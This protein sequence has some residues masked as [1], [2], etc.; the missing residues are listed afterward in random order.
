LIVT[1]VQEQ[2]NLVEYLALVN[3]YIDNN[4]T[5][6]MP[7]IPPSLDAVNTMCTFAG[8]SP[9]H[10]MG[11]YMFREAP[12][13]VRDIAVNALMAGCLPEYMP[14]ILAAHEVMFAR[15]PRD[16]DLFGTAHMTQT[17][18]TSVPA[19]VINGPIRHRLGIRSGP[20]SFGPGSRA[21]AAIGRAI[22]L[23]LL[24]LASG[25]PTAAGRSAVGSTFRLTAVFGEDEEHSPWTPL[26]VIAGYQPTDSTVTMMKITQPDQFVFR[27][28]SAERLLDVILDH[29]TTLSHFTDGL[30]IPEDPDLARRE[31]S[32]WRDAPR[33]SP[34]SGLGGGEGQSGASG[35]G[36]GGG[37]QLVLLGEE[38]RA[39]LAAWSHEQIREYLFG[40]RGAGRRG[41]T[42]GEMRFVGFI[43]LS[44]GF[45]DDDPDSKFI[46][47]RGRGTNLFPVAV[48]GHGWSS[49]LISGGS[50]MKKLPEIPAVRPIRVSGGKSSPI[51]EYVR[52]VEEAMESELGDSLPIL[53]PDPPAIE[54]MLAAS[55]RSSEEVLGRFERTVAGE[56]IYSWPFT[57]GEVA[58]TAH[59]AGL[60]HRTTNSSR[61]LWNVHGCS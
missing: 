1:T 13:T 43:G 42:V 44:A 61:I 21:N 23:S 8:L 11:K 54:R 18:L 55:G 28:D 53:P 52:R 4:K 38:H 7:I 56:R 29:G 16:E 33:M 60:E 37:R 27:T 24:N 5:D 26:H 47:R 49:M 20:D 12:V 9:D 32:L 25:M 41:R 34:T 19:M 36:G 14:I 2:P 17:V 22:R 3:R 57:M 40:D 35:E 10:E 45:T 59:M 31:R 30:H 51:A 58:A 15:G 48:G 46:R 50:V 39:L 6:G